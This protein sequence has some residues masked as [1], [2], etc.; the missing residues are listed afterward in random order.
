MADEN[1]TPQDSIDSDLVRENASFTDIV[2]Q[3]VEGLDKRLKTM[4]DAIRASEFE[5]LRAA[6][7][8]LK[9]SGGGYGYPILSERAAE[10]ERHAKARALDDCV[11]AFG[12]LKSLCEHVVVSTD[13]AKGE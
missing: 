1:H 11:H 2:V 4:E 6:A 10:L 8:Q 9:G 3:F 7:H 5:A 13:T 12:D